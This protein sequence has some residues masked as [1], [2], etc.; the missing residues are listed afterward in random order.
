MPVILAVFQ[1]LNLNKLR[2]ISLISDRMLVQAI[3]GRL[4]HNLLGP[5]LFRPS[6]F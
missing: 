3:C 1:I 5:C 4:E 2:L 6:G